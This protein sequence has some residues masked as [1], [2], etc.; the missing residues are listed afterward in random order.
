MSSILF[1]F[2]AHPKNWSLF[3][4]FCRKLG[5]ELSYLN[6]LTLEREKS[7]NKEG[8]GNEE[9][10]CCGEGEG[11]GFEVGEEEKERIVKCFFECGPRQITSFLTT[12]EE[13]ADFASLEHHPLDH[14]EILTKMRFIDFFFFSLFS[15]LILPKEKSSKKPIFLKLLKE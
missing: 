4:N 2:R 5:E 6:R 11:K 1:T 10:K 12:F 14:I 3:R 9:G 8:C 7:N 13:T 15:F